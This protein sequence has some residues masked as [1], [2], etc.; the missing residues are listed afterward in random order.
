MRVGLSK[1][2]CTAAL[3][4]VVSALACGDSVPPNLVL[5][6]LDT[7]R[8]DRTSV[9]GY[10]KP[11]TP[12]LERLAERG[13]VFEAAYAPT[14]ITGPS[15]ASLFTARYPKEHALV[16]NGQRLG[17]AE[18]LADRLASRGYQTA[19]IASSFVLDARFGLDRGFQRDAR[20]LCY[21]V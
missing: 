19:G 12:T 17:A 21:L 18:T 20:K 3:L 10:D 8:A 2:Q 13:V 1:I 14:P 9:L 11:T 7:V 15:H 6:T 16:R 5:I 4:S